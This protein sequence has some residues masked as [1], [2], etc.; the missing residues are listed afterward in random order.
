MHS[1]INVDVRDA[2][3]GDKLGFRRWFLIVAIAGALLFFVGS[4]YVMILPNGYVAW[5]QELDNK[6]G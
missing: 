6:F 1:L 4:I 3:S 2:G 5:L